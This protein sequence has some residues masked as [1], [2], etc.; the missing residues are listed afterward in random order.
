MI[1]MLSNI[2]GWICAGNSDDVLWL[3]M[4]FGSL[5]V[6]DNGTSEEEMEQL[7]EKMVQR[8]H[9]TIAT[10]DNTWCNLS[11]ISAIRSRNVVQLALSVF[12]HR[13]NY[14]EGREEVFLLRQCLWVLTNTRSPHRHRRRRE[15]SKV[16]GGNM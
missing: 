15:G 7:A 4:L 13:L 9:L 5:P 6:F 12:N 11:N 3:E 10:L 2:D 8:I 14:E 16:R 1:R